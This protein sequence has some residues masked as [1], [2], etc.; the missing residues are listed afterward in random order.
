MSDLALKITANTAAASAAFKDIAAQSEDFGKKV[1][2]FTEKFKDESVDRFIERQKIAAI[3]MQ[4]AGRDTDGLKSQVSAYQREIEKL[5]KAGLDPEDEA[6]KKLQGEYIRLSD[7]MNKNKNSTDSLNDQMQNLSNALNVARG[8]FSGIKND[9][10]N[11][12][13]AINSFASGTAEAGDAAAK[14]ARVIG[15]TAE[16]WQELS[17]AAKM[18]GVE[19]STLQ[20]SMQK[21]NKTMG[22]LKSGSGALAKYLGANDKAL[23]KNL[24]SAGNTEEA[25]TLLMDAINKA[26]DEF[27]R[28]QLAQEAFGKS[29]Q[30]LI[31]IAEVGTDGIAALREE[32]RKYGV[33]SNET[34][35]ASEAFKDAQE[36]AQ[37]A[38]EGVKNKLAAEFLPALTDV[39]NS[40]ADFIAS[41]GDIGSVLNTLIPI[42]AGAAAAIMSFMIITKVIML[43][44]A[45][46]AAMVALGGAISLS[47]IGGIAL[48]LGAVV[49]VAG[50]VA[51]ALN[52][53]A[54]GGEKL[55]KSM[56]DTSS[57]AE[58][59]LAEWQRLNGEKA[60]DE[61]TSTRLLA[62]YPGLADKMDVN[63]ASAS[64]LLKAIKELNEENAKKGAQEWID[65]LQK[66]QNKL[67]KAIEDCEEYA[68]KAKEN[69][70]Q[71]MAMGDVAKAKEFEEAMEVY[72][73]AVT[74]MRKKVV[75]DVDQAN[76]ILGTVG[77][78]L[79]DNGVIID[80]PVTI[81]GPTEEEKSA[82]AEAA[83]K[84]AQEIEKART[85][86]EA[87]AK[88]T[89][90]QRLGDIYS[91]NDK[92]INEGRI[93]DLTNY[94]NSIA[95][96]EKGGAEE[97]N[98]A[99]TEAATA[100]LNN[101]KI[102]ADERVFIEQA[103]NA[104]IAES[105]DKARKERED[106]EKEAERIR[107][108]TA[109][110]ALKDRLSM[111]GETEAQAENER[112]DQIKG[113]LE[114]RL[115]AEDAYRARTLEDDNLSGA[116][117]IQYMRDQA[118]LV[119][120]QLDEQYAMEQDKYKNNEEALAALRAQYDE[121]TKSAQAALHAWEEAELQ[122][123]EDAKTEIRRQTLDAA[124]DLAGSMSQL[125][126]SAGKE[127]REAA[128][129]ARALA[130]AQG[131]INTYLAFTAAL[132]NG[133]K[134]G[135]VVAGIQAAAVL[136]AGIA[137]QVKIMSTPIP[138]AETGGSFMVPDTG[139]VDGAL[140]RVNRGERVDVTPAGLAGRQGG[141]QIFNLVFD[142]QALAY[143]INKLARGG[144][145]YTLQLAGNL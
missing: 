68:I 12:Y 40:F 130:S 120:K 89:L 139:R 106:A 18:S 92:A 13:N 102:R 99:I 7:E 104:A 14:T 116:A 61:E 27:T 30:D 133:A 29:G 117:R 21:L 54:H 100:L 144:E 41:I 119:Q 81:S 22:D 112:V 124:V 76:A 90:S 20:S 105:N 65:K 58:S 136:A 125:I 69:I 126:E 43:V 23:L 95:S 63:T 118:A 97:R 25:F 11:V 132:A 33:I 87:E 122:R 78:K 62:L 37:K 107:K 111:L 50:Y 73:E 109:L 108:E 80:I 31:K 145:L 16:A 49:T 9:I 71:A 32:A 88:K 82:A 79:G 6:I 52:D 4:A 8:A 1:E 113:I 28:A 51:K 101:T 91:Q 59:M 115:A 17:Y 24:Q 93:K 74:K 53:A 129:A 143:A 128:I 70:R 83:R 42:V 26:P 44:Q 127:N 131:L 47:G 10:T 3:A 134:L 123:S 45:L 94:L 46:Q 5:V 84:A 48:A 96:L 19:S 114:K 72:A 98:R 55:A 36:R 121:N 103:V 77:K 86:A 67:N 39:I 138:A 75:N 135:P 110:A 66:D 34:A 35:A 85:E 60:L 64:D 142:G 2:Q 56:Q 140:M 57:K 141:Q 15:T 137:Q 38:V